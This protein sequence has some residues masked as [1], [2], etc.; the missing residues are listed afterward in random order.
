MSPHTL[1]ETHTFGRIGG[2]AQAI[3]W[4]HEITMKTGLAQLTLRVPRSFVEA[5]DRLRPHLAA[6]K[7][8]RL[9][10]ELTDAD[11]Y[12]LIMAEGLEQLQ[13]DA[14]EGKAYNE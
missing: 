6:R 7:E 3:L 11:V 12:R 13:A 8:F 5:A 9:A 14:G 10:D 1:Y 2:E 4:P